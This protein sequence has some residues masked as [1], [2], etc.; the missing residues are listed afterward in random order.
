[1]RAFV[2]LV[3]VAV[4]FLL[5][6]RFY[7][8]SSVEGG[9]V[10]G[11]VAPIA[12]DTE[13]A[14]PERSNSSGF[15]TRPEHG[16]PLAGPGSSE[17]VAA[18]L[19][20]PDPI[21]A[22]S[23]SWLEGVEPPAAR[24]EGEIEVAAA[25]L[26]GSDDDVRQAAAS[27]AGFPPDRARMAE[28]FALA[29][30]GRARQGLVLAAELDEAGLS[31]RE[32]ALLQTA[33]GGE[34]IH[35]G[36]I[37]AGMSESPLVFA[38]EMALLEFEAR[39]DLAARRYSAAARAFSSLLLRELDAPWRASRTLLADWTEGLDEAQSH[40][41]WS[42]KGAWPAVE[43]T[44]PPGGTAIG[45][46]KE[47]LAANPGR[48]MCAGLIL[49]SNAVRGYLQANQV[50]RV[51][52]D[53]VRM[54]VDLSARWAV[55]L[56]GDE[57]AGSWPIGIGRPGEETITGEFAAGNKL[58]N[59]PWMRVG[60]PAVRFGDPKNPLGTR[61]I[62]WL[63]DGAPSSYG[64][65]GTKEPESIGMASSDGC[66]RFHNASVERLFEILPEGAPIVVRE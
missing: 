18:E 20:T 25:L 29:L 55:Y 47:Y 37:E 65:H 48:V 34:K 10:T 50:L 45:I 54:L 23:P 24:D 15:L 7:P 36:P 64:F 61:W 3:L 28:A 42:P 12:S 46:R 1:M 51:P 4:S 21:P 5:F 63:E 22:A 2:L 16:E 14:E 27:I 30:E 35:V 60:Y 39:A 57:V 52:T 11:P 17:A 31:A 53:P 59:P 6:V 62:G 49:E 32:K 9:L 58:E 56:A 66:V 44:V 33:L 13:G 43:M 40:H 41:R 8:A 19:P 26:H 38:M